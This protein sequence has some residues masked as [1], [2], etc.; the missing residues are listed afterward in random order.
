MQMGNEMA[1]SSGIRQCYRCDRVLRKTETI[2]DDKPFGLMCL[3]CEDKV[4]GKW[5]E[6]GDEY[7]LV[8]H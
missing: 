4:Y 6:I 2:V 8:E 7:P 5:M 1:T 3:Q